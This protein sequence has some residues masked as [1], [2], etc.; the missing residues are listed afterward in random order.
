MHSTILWGSILPLRS[1][2]EPPLPHSADNWF[3]I[4]RLQAV[5]AHAITSLSD[6]HATQPS[7]LT[8]AIMPLLVRMANSWLSLTVLRS[9]SPETALV[10]SAAIIRCVFDAYL[11]AMYI[12][13]DPAQS[14]ARSIDYIQYE[15]VEQYIQHSRI[16]QHNSDL[17]NSLRQSPHRQ[18]G[19][20]RLKQDYDAVAAK[21]MTKGGKPRDRWYPGNLRDLAKLANREDEYDY[22][23]GIFSG[24]VHS[25]YHAASKGPPIG[26]EYVDFVAV[27]YCMSLIIVLRSRNLIVLSGTSEEVASAWEEG[28]AELKA[29]SP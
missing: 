11:Q 1:W 21:Y 15:A 7:N 4:G 6:R 3:F 8:T 27:R 26:V 13:D 12:L 24:S 22:F 19:E 14:D 20:L 17:A 29:G 2:S 10:D 25:S 28:E 5:L 18:A 9:R 23:A 16:M